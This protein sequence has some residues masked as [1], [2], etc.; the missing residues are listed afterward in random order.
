MGKKDIIHMGLL[1]ATLALAAAYGIFHRSEV[2]LRNW[3]INSPISQDIEWYV[4]DTGDMLALLLLLF[5]MQA[6]E[7]NIQFKCIIR[8]FVVYHLFQLMHYWYNYG[9]SLIWDI[10]EIV[11][12]MCFVMYCIVAGRK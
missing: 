2:R 1:L 9:Q 12:L 5:V 10:T 8:A 6:R 7:A 11:V 4:K 3:F